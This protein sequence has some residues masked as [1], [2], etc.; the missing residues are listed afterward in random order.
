MAFAYGFSQCSVNADAGPNVDNSSCCG[1]KV[2]GGSPTGS[3]TGCPCTSFTYSWSPITGLNNSTIANPTSNATSD[4]TY[5]VTVTHQTCGTSSDAVFYDWVPENSCC[6]MMEDLQNKPS[7]KAKGMKLFPNPTDGRFT[8]ILKDSDTPQT[9]LAYNSAGE[10]VFEKQ[11]T[12]SQCLIDISSLPK[13]IYYI[14]VLMNKE[15]LLFDKI[16]IQ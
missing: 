14:Q 15:E 4:Q 8:V 10:K 9:I 3:A 2:I 6:R 13:G 16:V 11:T 1:P 12:D 5:T 7:K